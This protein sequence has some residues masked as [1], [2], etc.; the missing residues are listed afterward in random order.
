M[1]M[2]EGGRDGKQLKKQSSMASGNSQ[3]R[4]VQLA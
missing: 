2:V 3:D 1:I 4:P